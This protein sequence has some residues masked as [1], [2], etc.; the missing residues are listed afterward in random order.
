MMKRRYT[1]ALALLLS[2]SVASAY[3]QEDST[4]ATTFFGKVG[5]IVKLITNKETPAVLGT[6]IETWDTTD[7]GSVNH[8]DSTATFRLVMNQDVVLKIDTGS[9]SLTLTETGAGATGA[10]D[11]ETLASFWTLY[12][13]GDGQDPTTPTVFTAQAWTGIASV[14]GTLGVS[15]AG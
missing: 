14:D 8:T 13:D 3:A 5:S 2:M 15:T 4:A 1:V 9:S 6:G 7:S 12:T 11:T 10:E